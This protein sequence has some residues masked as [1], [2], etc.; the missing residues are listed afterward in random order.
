M[1]CI[2]ISLTINYSV[3]ASF[4]IGIRGRNKKEMFESIKNTLFKQGNELVLAG[5]KDV[6][7]F[8]DQ[9]KSFLNEYYTHVSHRSTRLHDSLLLQETGTSNGQKNVLFFS[10]LDCVWLFGFFASTQSS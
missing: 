3:P 6:D 10:A 9:Q 7:D 2:N 4:Q 5:Q 1:L 8:F